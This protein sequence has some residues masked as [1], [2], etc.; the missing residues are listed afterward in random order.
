ML[1]ELEK[2]TGKMD[3][4][5]FRTRSVSWLGKNLA[6]RNQSH[7]NFARAM[8]LIETLRANGVCF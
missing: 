1:N 4:P 7:P 3:V 2:L 6:K 8:Q 5:S